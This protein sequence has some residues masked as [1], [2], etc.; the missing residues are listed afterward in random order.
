MTTASRQLGSSLLFADRRDAGE[1]LARS[2]EREARLGTIVVGLA[3][4]G[5]VVG[6]AVAGALGLPLDLVA[7]RKV[8]HPGNLEY[9]VGAVA[10]GTPAYVR[11][12]DGLTPRELGLAIDLARAEADRL[13]RT[14]RRGRP[15]PAFQ[16]RPVVL[17]DDGL[18]TGASMVAAARWVHGQGADRIVAAAPVASRE[19]ISILRREV[20][21]VVCPHVVDDFRSVGLFYAHFPPV[22]DDEVEQ[23]LGPAGSAG[24][25]AAAVPNPPPSFATW[26]E[27]GRRTRA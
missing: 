13:D 9:A 17:V 8:R 2:L 7:V 26:P 5:I 6:A 22:D 14:L 21:D 3:R 18:A 20:C 16:D 1:V 15:Q 12:R 25:Q 24:A 23:L 27:R 4:G 11:G 10:P 19:A